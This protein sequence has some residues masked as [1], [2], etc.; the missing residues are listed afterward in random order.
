MKRSPGFY[1]ET[2]CWILDLPGDLSGN[3][4]GLFSM[5][6]L[7]RLCLTC[8]KMRLSVH[9]KANIVVSG[10]SCSVLGQYKMFRGIKFDVT[11]A[12]WENCPTWFE[13]MEKMP[14]VAR[15]ISSLNI[16]I[17]SE[18]VS[19]ILRELEGGSLVDLWVNNIMTGDE[20]SICR[21]TR[22]K[23]LC[24]GEAE[25][26]SDTDLGAL[27]NLTDLS[28]GDA[29]LISSAGF[30]HLENLTKLAL[31]GPEF[32]NRTK[33]PLINLNFLGSTKIKDLYLF[34]RDIGS[35]DWM[36]M[37]R[38]TKLRLMAEKPSTQPVKIDQG[39]K[40]LTR[41]RDLEL[42]GVEEIDVREIRELRLTSLKLFY[43]SFCRENMCE[44]SVN[45]WDLRGCEL[46]TIGIGEWGGLELETFRNGEL[47]NPWQYIK[48]KLLF[49]ATLRKLEI[50][51]CYLADVLVR[52][53]LINLTSLVLSHSITFEERKIK[54]VS[55]V[56]LINL[57]ELC[58]NKEA[59]IT[60]ADIFG[61]TKLTHLVMNDMITDDGIQGLVEMR[62]L[63]LNGLV[64]N[65]GISGLKKLMFLDMNYNGYVGNR[66][67]T[68]L[69]E[70]VELNLRMNKKIS[71]ISL[72][73][74]MHLQKIE[75]E[76]SIVR[77]DFRSL[78]ANGVNIVWNYADREQFLRLFPRMS[79][80]MIVKIG[81]FDVEYEQAI[82][83][84]HVRGVAHVNAA[85][86]DHTFLVL[87]I[88]LIMI[89]IL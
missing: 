84:D 61:L 79:D 8:K 45:F 2:K 76:F 9:A 81:R 14:R 70:L 69:K 5:I 39:V 35:S 3:I 49:P 82:F 89:F 78:E 21:F 23:K 24:I 83:P 55:I 29:P 85:N 18:E 15:S 1:N 28:L 31:K 56:G 88:F 12:S 65:R 37:T 26:F 43:V 54:Y 44:K 40:Q 20:K 87:L 30:Y 50:R 68:G 57:R 51:S 59:K 16:R 62:R 6:D 67:L 64:T 86:N 34:N 27:V 41:L 25:T 22:L 73:A 4:L 32:I 72:K 75:V 48:D 47:V 74:L 33:I 42:I 80:R 66:G 36:Y 71:D 58:L 46:E 52:N 10:N 7:I 60:D 63:V 38:L 19:K 77:F 53:D 11:A 13:E 17:E